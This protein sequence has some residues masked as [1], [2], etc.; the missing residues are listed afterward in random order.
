M[1]PPDHCPHHWRIHPPLPS[2]LLPLIHIVYSPL[3]FFSTPFPSPSWYR[4]ELWWALSLVCCRR[5]TK[6]PPSS[7]STYSGTVL[8]ECG[9][10]FDITFLTTL[11]RFLWL[12]SNHWL[13]FY[14]A[15]ALFIPCEVTTHLTAIFAENFLSC[16]AILASHSSKNR[17]CSISFFLLTFLFF[18]FRFKFISIILIHHLFL[19][20]LLLLFLF[21]QDFPCI[22][23]FY[24]DAWTD[25]W[26]QDRTADDEGNATNVYLR[27]CLLSF[28]EPQCLT[29]STIALTQWRA[30]TR[31]ITR[32]HPFVRSP[33]H[34]TQY[35]SPNAHQAIEF[36]VKRAE[37][38]DEERKE[39]NAQYDADLSAARKAAPQDRWR[40]TSAQNRLE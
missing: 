35:S 37:H 40:H 36:E 5:S 14:C 3:A 34:T 21:I 4:T 33:P 7:P 39:K 28:K 32:T 18:S 27:V 10:D 17:W 9:I 20:N 13:S 30:K 15:A 8:I 19:F 6:N 12:F 1:A 29:H 25:G 26:L 23:E 16:H 11:W 24:G 22:F 2:P 38:R 31:L